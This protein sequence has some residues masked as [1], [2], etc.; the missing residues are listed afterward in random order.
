MVVAEIIFSSSGL[1][2]FKTKNPESTKKF[3]KKIPTS[4]SQFVISVGINAGA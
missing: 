1:F 4:R 3:R 2:P